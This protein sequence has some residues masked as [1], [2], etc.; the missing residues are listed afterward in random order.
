[1][2]HNEASKWCIMSDTQC[3]TWVT[4][5]IVSLLDIK[6]IAGS[7]ISEEHSQEHEA[8]LF[9]VLRTNGGG[10]R[11]AFKN[12]EVS[13]R[14]STRQQERGHTADGPAARPHFAH[15]SARSNPG[16]HTFRKCARKSSP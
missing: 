16:F 9:Q 15:R 13:A 12:R 14:W 11:V 3:T 4:K 1:M 5:G 8:R 7:V 6:G 2:L 10:V